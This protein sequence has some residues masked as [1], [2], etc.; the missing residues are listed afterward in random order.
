M[1]CVLLG[2]TSRSTAPI[3]GTDGRPA[4]GSIASLEPIRLGGAEQWIL[5]RGRDADKPLL[6]KLH[7][8]PGQA[9][10]ATAP[11]NALLEKDF[12]VV[13]WDQ[14]G[15][16][17]SAASIDPRAAM[18]MDQLVS[19][20]VELTQA[21]LLRFRRKSLILVGHSWGSA[22]GL[23]AIQR[24]PDLYR[25]FV[26]TGQMANFTQAMREGH[27]LLLE[28]ARQRGKTD[29]VAELQAIGPPPYIGP[30]ADSRRERYVQRLEESGHLWHSAET[31]D[32]VG[33]MLSSPEYAWPEKLA[34]PRAARSSFDL[35]LPDL[36]KLDMTTLVPRVAV[37][38]YFALGRHDYMAP[39]AVSAR[40][41]AA[42]GAPR[43][44]WIWFEHSAHF[45]HWEEPERFHALLTRRVA[46]ETPE[47][48]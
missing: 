17:K 4:R 44:E 28:D 2:C 36:L 33:W 40:Y 35:L 46:A 10:I 8:G 39:P 20:T 11:L 3:T 45:P 6:L 19:D 31:F 43:K 48:R 5:I 14:R 30:D 24:R 23:Q 16:G 12:V 34:Y 22:I 21:L 29:L 41:F 42:L 26:S 37:P 7:G 25:A 1:A 18:T 32:R 47:P 38:V 9:E 15:S 13:E 27:R